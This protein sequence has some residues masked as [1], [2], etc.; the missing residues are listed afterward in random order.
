MRYYF[1]TGAGLSKESGLNTFRDSNNGTWLNYNINEVCNFLT[2]KNN[3]STVFDFYSNRKKEVLNAKPNSAHEFLAELQKELGKDRVIIFTQNIDDLLERAGC[4]DVIHL[5][6][7]LH[8]MKC[9][10]CGN[11]WGIADELFTSHRKC[12]KCDCFR[13]IKPNVVFFKETAPEYAK[14]HILRKTI[15]AEDSLIAIG[16]SFNVL[17]EEDLIPRQRIGSENNVQINP[18]LT[19]TKYWGINLNMTANDGLIHL[20]KTG[21]FK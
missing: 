19:D 9:Y 10:G 17:G 2:Y 13:A 4:K 15:L 7:N 11:I 18:E 21:F 16:T 1:F 8:E 14:L 12:P 20:R 3:L 5:H 6:G